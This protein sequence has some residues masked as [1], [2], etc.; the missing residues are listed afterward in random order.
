MTVSLEYLQHCSGQT[1]YGVNV[2]EKVV[3]LGQ[4]GGEMARHPFLGKVLALKGGTALNLCFGPPKR[5]S[6]DLDFNYIGHHERERMLADRPKVEAGVIELARRMG[7]RVQQSADAFAGRK[8]YLVYRSV[9]VQEDRIEVDLNY[10]FRVPLVAT[11]FRSLWQPGDL[12]C[13]R[14]HVAGLAE[15][16]IGKLMA[17]LDR[18]AIR[19]VWDVANLPLPAIEV[20]QT[21]GFRAYFIALSAILEHPLPTYSKDRLRSFVTERR[22]TDHLVPMLVAGASFS[23]DDLVDRAWDAIGGFF[24]LATHEVQYIDGVEHGDLRLKLLFGE[25]QTEAERLANHP[26]ILWKMDNVRRYRARTPRDG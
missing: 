17:L 19:D 10:L 24:K 21:H 16:L 26:A 3:R 20:M 15:I 1:G 18:G 7:Y 14:V 22:V 4:V 12:E 9:M 13:P 11:G 23:A 2:L 6:V 5:L 25:N 8:F